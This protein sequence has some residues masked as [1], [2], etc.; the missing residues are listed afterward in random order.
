ME[1]RRGKRR[2]EKLRELYLHFCPNFLEK[3]TLN[4]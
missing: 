4:G 1:N 3:F 2:K